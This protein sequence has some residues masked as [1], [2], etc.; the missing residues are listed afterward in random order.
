[1]RTL[2]EDENLYFDLQ[3]DFGITKHMG[4]REATR[5]LGELCRLR[6]GQYV[7]EVGCGIGSTACYIVEKRGCRVI[8]VDIAEKMVAR[9][10]DRAKKRGVEAR[11]EFR[12]ADAQSLPFEDA[13]FDVVID[14]SVTAF[15]ENKQKTVSEYVRVAR[16][17]GYVG[18]NEATWIEIPSPELVKY[19]SLIMARADFLTSEGW[20]ALLE[21]A[22]LGDIQ[23]ASYKFDARRQ[24]IEELRQ[25][26]LRENARAW[27]RFLT[28]SVVNPAYR[29]FGK[30]VL[31]APRSI[32]RFMKCIG[33]GLYVGRKQEDVQT[34][35]SPE[36]SVPAG[37]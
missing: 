32:L 29:K 13:V 12:V 14:E 2:P 27:Y 24:Y 30:E 7:L 6:D 19:V 15:V 37:L 22:G 9:S 23:V 26:D 34:W 1:M 5:E 21:G 4:G 20:R 28:Q 16:P 10:T 35:P 11:V 17:G 3:A 36:A 18:L 33:Y 8:G 31:T 25:L